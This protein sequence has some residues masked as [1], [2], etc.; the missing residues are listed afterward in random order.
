[1][2]AECVCR[3]SAPACV[4]N[5]TLIPADYIRL[6]GTNT[7]IHFSESQKK[8]EIL[9]GVCCQI[10]ISIYL[11]V[12]VGKA[13]FHCMAQLIYYTVAPKALAYNM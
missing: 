9:S 10:L 13:F 1:M 3:A 6:L 4:Y 12:P 8:V 7:L 5:Y 2:C 11:S